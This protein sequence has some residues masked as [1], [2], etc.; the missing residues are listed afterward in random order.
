MSFLDDAVYKITL[1]NVVEVFAR[2]VVRMWCHG[3]R[4]CLHCPTELI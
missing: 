3:P 4:W 2:C 1:R